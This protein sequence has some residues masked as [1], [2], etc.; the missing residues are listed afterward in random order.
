ML[1]TKVQDNNDLSLDKALKR[2]RKHASE[3]KNEFSK[4]LKVK[5]PSPEGRLAGPPKS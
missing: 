5:S 4:S 3:S 2:M 1:T